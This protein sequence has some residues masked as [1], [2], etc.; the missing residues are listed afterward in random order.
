MFDHVKTLN[1]I[2]AFRSKRDQA[3]D[4]QDEEILS[5]KPN[6]VMFWRNWILWSVIDKCEEIPRKV[7]RSEHALSLNP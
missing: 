1:E 7:I 3:E 6:R 2:L 5:Y 4:K